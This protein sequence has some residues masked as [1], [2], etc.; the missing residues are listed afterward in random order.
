M[1]CLP[2]ESCSL[3]DLNK[4]VQKQKNIGTR[5][6]CSTKLESK[7]IYGHNIKTRE[8]LMITHDMHQ[9]WEKGTNI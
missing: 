6:I 8:T 1:L 5:N 9:R 3:Q 7:K 2:R 4:P